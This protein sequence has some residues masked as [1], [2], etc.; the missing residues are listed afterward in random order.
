MILVL[1]SGG[2]TSSILLAEAVAQHGAENVRALTFRGPGTPL[3]SVAFAKH[4]AR[5]YSVDHKT[6]I[7]PKALS[8][9]TPA[10]DPIKM[11]FM[12]AT[13]RAMV[14]TENVSAIWLGTRGYSLHWDRRPEYIEAWDYLSFL[15]SSNRVTIEQ[16]FRP[17]EM[18]EIMK[19]GEELQF[20]WLLSFCCT[21]AVE[22]EKSCGKCYA[23]VC[24]KL[25]F[26]GA[27]IP[28]PTP[29]ADP[30]AGVFK[31]DIEVKP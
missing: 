2:L 28:D 21:T 27:G 9:L 6:V 15:V 30:T 22:T 24:R 26:D 20:P 1:L 7:L 3:R 17:L 16:P 31:D 11:D 14:E 10:S 13:A 23:C 8:D 19:R 25:S 5:F 29:Y 4:L 12:L 18:T